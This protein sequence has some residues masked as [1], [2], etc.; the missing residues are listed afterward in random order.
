MI[1][2]VEIHEFLAMVAKMRKSDDSDYNETPASNERTLRYVIERAR[3]L[4]SRLDRAAK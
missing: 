2:L 4:Q 3:D 1:L